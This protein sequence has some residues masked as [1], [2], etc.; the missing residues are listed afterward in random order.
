M[1]PRDAEASTGMTL[2]EEPGNRGV[3]MK[4]HQVMYMMEIKL[5][6]PRQKRTDWSCC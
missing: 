1:I 5:T 3:V 4:E 2:D 6:T